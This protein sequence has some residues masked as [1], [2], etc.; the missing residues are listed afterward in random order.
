MHFMQYQ[1]SYWRVVVEKQKQDIDIVFM[2]K[3]HKFVN[4]AANTDM[5]LWL[6]FINFAAA[7]W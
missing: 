7:L 2:I 1:S 6:N 4:F 3:F 5:C